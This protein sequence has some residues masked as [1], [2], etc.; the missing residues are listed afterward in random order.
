ML[1][2]T[3]TPD[4]IGMI[5]AETDADIAPD[6]EVTDWGPARRIAFPVNIA[7]TPHRWDIAEIIQQESCTVMVRNG[8]L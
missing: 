3:A 8:K 1:S 2:K 7:G 4:C 6:V 5:A